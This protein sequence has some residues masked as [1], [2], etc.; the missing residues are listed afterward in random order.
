ME[1]MRNI[2]IK[3]LIF[4]LSFSVFAT[5]KDDEGHFAGRVSK[6]NLEAGLLRVK[7][8]FPN[9]KYINK[10][11]RVELWNQQ[12][13]GRRC[14]AYVTG[15]TSDYIL[16][17]VPNAED[18]SK[19]ISLDH[20]VYLEFFSQD[21]VNNL[22]MGREVVEILLKKR[23]ALQSKMSRSQ[24]EIDAHIEK[25][26]AVNLRYEVLREKLVAEW[27]KEIQNL[28]ED[29]INALRNYKGLEIRL[30]EVNHKLEKYRIEDENLALDRWSLDPKLY[31]RK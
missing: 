1:L 3:Y 10:K 17:K 30:D 6:F 25:V 12:R 5:Y 20:G 11:D 4:F 9:V 19:T 28:E 24:K 31:Y 21:L 23:L 22:K 15:R 7:V 18:C 16:F 29:K 26:N 14:L 27:Q 8:E 2:S 13:M